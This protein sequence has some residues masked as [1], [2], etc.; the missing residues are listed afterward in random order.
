MRTLPISNLSGCLLL[1]RL[2]LNHVCAVLG[3]K[4]ARNSMCFEWRDGV[5]YDNAVVC[6]A[7]GWIWFGY[8]MPN[9]LSDYYIVRVVN[10]RKIYAFNVKGWKNEKT[11]L[12]KLS[13]R[14]G[15]SLRH[16]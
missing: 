11:T 3:S 1:A 15:L 4:T 13:L 14:R 12:S 9:L 5:T 7:S 16:L 2:I 6:V 10:G 8:K